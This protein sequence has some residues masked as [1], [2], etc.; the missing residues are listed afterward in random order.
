MING[1][2]EICL[3]GFGKV[4]HTD[5]NQTKPLQITNTDPFSQ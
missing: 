1:E 5:G 3:R 4:A 2:R